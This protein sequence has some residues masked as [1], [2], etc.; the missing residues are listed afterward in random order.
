MVHTKSELQVYGNFINWLQRLSTQYYPR[1]KLILFYHGKGGFIPQMLIRALQAYNLLNPFCQLVKCFV[2]NN[3]MAQQL[4]RFEGGDYM[5]LNNLSRIYC[6]PKPPGY[7]FISVASNRAKTI[8]AVV[9][10]LID[11]ECNPCS[12]LDSVLDILQP[13]AESVAYHL[14]EMAP[15]ELRARLHSLRPL[16]S[17]QF[18]I[19]QRMRFFKYRALL[20]ESN[21]DLE[22]LKVTWQYGGVAGLT[23]AMERTLNLSKARERQ[24]VKFLHNYFMQNILVSAGNERDTVT[25]STRR[26]LP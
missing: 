9:V 10:E 25:N 13:H 12:K 24:L 6:G 22:T 2:N 4:L 17:S 7:E 19:A 14:S 16:L 15:I 26:A 8:Y 20:A 1:S 5:S 11:V 23:A 18:T 21:F 3:L